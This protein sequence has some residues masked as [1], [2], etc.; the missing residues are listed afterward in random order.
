MLFQYHRLLLLCSPLLSSAPPVVK[1]APPFPLARQLS[2]LTRAHISVRTS[3]KQ[4]QCQLFGQSELYSL[5]CD[6]QFLVNVAV[7]TQEVALVLDTETSNTW[8]AGIDFTCVNIT[9][10][11]T[12]PEMVSGFWSLVTPEATFQPIANGTFAI[13]YVSS[14]CLRFGAR[15]DLATNV[16]TF[17]HLW[18]A[19]LLTTF[20][21][22]WRTSIWILR[23]K[24]VTIGG[25]EI[26]QQEIIVV[27][28]AAW[29]GN[30]VIAGL[31]GFSWPSI[32][33][34]CPGTNVFADHLSDSTTATNRSSIINTIFFVEN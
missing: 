30:S 14:R 15:I 25:T 4:L 11:D 23:Y 1:K 9:A 28:V 6:S 29:E 27:D 31:T 16:Y 17:S 34:A 32:T 21:G 2:R 8:L 3:S 19:K 7:G 22:R 13:I 33:G 18:F 24:A 20:H 10:N 5:D 26:S 12:L